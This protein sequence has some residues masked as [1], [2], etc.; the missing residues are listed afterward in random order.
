[1]VFKFI[2]YT[3]LDMEVDMKKA[4]KFCVFLGL[5]LLCGSCLAG[6]LVGMSAPEIMIREWITLNP[7][8][9]N[10][11]QNLAYVVEFWATWCPPCRDN[12]PHLIKLT[13]KYRKSGVL[14]I[15]LSADN[16]ADTVREFVRRKGINYHVA[17]DNGSAELFEIRGYPTVFVVDRKGKVVW[18]G[19]PSKYE[20]EQAIKK[21][22][23]DVQPPP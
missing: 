13:D 8:D 22:V 7:P 14:F 11:L 18:R 15:S 23:K 19:H 2:F 1:M 4:W 9:L 6:D 17:L 10:N 20:F 16:S 21:A 5:V 12:V 3:T